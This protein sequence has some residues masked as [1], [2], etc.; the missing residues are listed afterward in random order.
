MG[1]EGSF[2]LQL[3]SRKVNNWYKDKDEYE[4]PFNHFGDQFSSVEAF[5]RTEQV[6]PAN[7]TIAGNGILFQPEPGCIFMMPDNRYL[8]KLDFCFQL[9]VLYLRTFLGPP[10]YFACPHPVLMLRK[11]SKTIDYIDT[12]TYSEKNC[13]ANSGGNPASC[14]WKIQRFFPVLLSFIWVKYTYKV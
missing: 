4:G 12:I 11:H 2:I 3:K 7:V 5:K 6:F 13:D 9:K 10:L 14:C 1:V 8:Q